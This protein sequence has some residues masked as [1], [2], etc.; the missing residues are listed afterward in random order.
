MSAAVAAHLARRYFGRPPIIPHTGEPGVAS[1]DLTWQVSPGATGYAVRTRDLTAGGSWQR[2]AHHLTGTSYQV[3]GLPAWHEVQ[4][5][6][7]P[8]KGQWEA[9]PDAWSGVVD[10]EVLGDRLD[11]PRAQV[12]SSSSAGT[13]SL[14]WPAVPGATS[15]SVQWRRADQPELWRVGPTTTGASATVAGLT[16]RT[17]YAFRVLAERSSLLSWFSDEV[18]AVVPPLPAVRRVRAARA[19]NGAVLTSGERVAD[20][21]SY[22]VTAA[23]AASCVRKPRGGRFALVADG[24]ARPR[25]R[26]RIEAPAVWVR[27]VAVRGGVEGDLARSSTSCVRLHP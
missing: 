11:P 23:P 4:V 7:A 8:S 18:A 12:T 1:L 22:V 9:A 20:A 6:L 3:T 19:P 27:W 16:N 10:L 24:V 17:G 21:T 25:H 2:V 14:S 26:F 13:M 15:Y 5:Q